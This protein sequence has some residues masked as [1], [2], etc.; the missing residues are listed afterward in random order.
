MWLIPSRG[1]P[2]QLDR[3][4]KACRSMGMTTP[5]VVRLDGDDDT[6]PAYMDLERPKDWAF[7][8]A[9]RGPL[10]AVYNGGFRAMPD[11]DW[12]GF[13][14]D[15]VVPETAGFD[16]LLIDAA[17]LDGMAYGD[18]G[19][20]GSGL[21]THFVLGGD[22]VRSCGFLALPGLERLFIDTSWNDIAHDRGTHRYLP[23]VVLRHHH[24]SNKMALFDSTYRKPAKEIDRQIYESWRSARDESEKP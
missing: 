9:R 12:Y 15:D 19:I 6:L 3:L 2:A 4:M 10:S 18:D 11:L 1:R 21:G 14:A 16:R 24:F 8:V 7:V 5:A 23:H 22:L 20:N 13:L 17:G